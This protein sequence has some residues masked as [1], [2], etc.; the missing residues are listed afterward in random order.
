MILRLHENLITR[1]VPSLNSHHDFD[2]EE[3]IELIFVSRF[4]KR[5]L[6]RSQK[7]C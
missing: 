3:K 6:E 5:T 7:V 4:Q 2:L 1:F